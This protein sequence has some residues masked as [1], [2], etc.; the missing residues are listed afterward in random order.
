MS[1]AHQHRGT[2]ASYYTRTSS[3]LF[4]EIEKLDVPDMNQIHVLKMFTM[5][6]LMLPVVRARNARQT[7]YHFIDAQLVLR[8]SGYARENWRT[9]IRLVN[10]VPTIAVVDHDR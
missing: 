5:A 1:R 8:I 6:I 9:K 7:L 4:D 10:V 3:R 2:T